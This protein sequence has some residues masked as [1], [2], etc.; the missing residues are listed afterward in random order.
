M[1]KIETLLA[2]VGSG[3]MNALTYAAEY[4]SESRFDEAVLIIAN[5]PRGVLDEILFE[6]ETKRFMK[7]SNRK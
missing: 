7:K 4:N 3:L 6:Y 5:I 1:R 2:M